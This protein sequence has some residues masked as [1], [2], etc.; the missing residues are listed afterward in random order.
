MS[1]KD[2]NIFISKPGRPWFCFL[3]LSTLKIPVG[4]GI[5]PRGFPA[6]DLPWDGGA[7][8][9]ELRSRGCSRTSALPA[10]S[11][12]TFAVKT[13]GFF[14]TFPGEL[15]LGQTAPAARATRENNE[16]EKGWN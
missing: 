13:L 11:S 8:R 1:L 10:S 9:A 5:T 7:G 16:S 2:K 12:W 15:F 14:F 6:R 3:L 4:Q